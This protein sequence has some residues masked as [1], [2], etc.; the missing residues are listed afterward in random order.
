MTTLPETTGTEWLTPLPRTTGMKGQKSTVP[1][2]ATGTS[3]REMFDVHFLYVGDI[4]SY[5]HVNVSHSEQDNVNESNG[6]EEDVFDK[7]V[8]FPMKSARQ[9]GNIFNL[10]EQLILAGGFKQQANGATVSKQG[11]FAWN[12]E[13][14]AFQDDQEIEDR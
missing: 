9:V 3:E 13:T 8:M 4:N 5:I 14:L 12:N 2:S 11:L 7:V 10:G 1:D 6:K